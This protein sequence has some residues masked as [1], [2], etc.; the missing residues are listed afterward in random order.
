M[1]TKAA[2]LFEKQEYTTV[3][4]AD[5]KIPENPEKNSTMLVCGDGTYLL[6]KNEIG[7]FLRK[8][9]SMAMPALADGPSEGEFVFSLPKIP[10]EIL[11]TQVSFYRYV[12]LRHN[13]AE[14]YTMILWD[15]ITKEY[16][17]VCPKQKISKGG[18]QYDLGKEW[19]P[20][21]YLPVVSCHSH[22][23]MGAFFSG[24]DDADEKGDMCYMVMGNLHKPNPTFRIRASVAG[25]QIKFLELNELFT[26][27]ED[28]W[29]LQTPNWLARN[30]NFPKEWMDKL[31]VEANYV[32][33]HM[34]QGGGPRQTFRYGSYEENGRYTAKWP[35]TE[36]KDRQLS[37]FDQIEAI[38]TSGRTS[39]RIAAQKFIIDLRRETVTDALSNFL[40]NVIDA[41]YVEEL[42]TAFTDVE[43]IVALVD[44]EDPFATDINLDRDDGSEIPW[45]TVNDYVKQLNMMKE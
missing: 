39:L 19:S 42:A 22:N 34:L 10:D 28:N 13:D 12:M 7:R 40:D 45:E 5:G 20:E 11:K 15:R 1:K 29:K 27:D 21:R 4:C 32:N 23:S 3:V 24:T 37:F 31:N 43:E 30:E 18:V 38:Q 26:I 2:L 9:N 36:E 44:E 17:V 35:T 8:M 33:I 25:G 41:G 6:R 16:I 14:A